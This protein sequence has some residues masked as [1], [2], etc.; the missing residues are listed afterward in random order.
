MVKDGWLTEDEV[1]E[2]QSAAAPAQPMNGNTSKVVTG[3][4]EKTIEE[5]KKVGPA[6]DN[7]RTLSE[8]VR[9]KRAVAK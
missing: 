4:Y 5:T 1:K 7:V 8:L 9:Q 3:I 2:M 6:L